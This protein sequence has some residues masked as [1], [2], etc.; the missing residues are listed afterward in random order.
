M[1]ATAINA[2]RRQQRKLCDNEETCEDHG[3]GG[4]EAKARPGSR[5]AL[6]VAR[7]IEV[8]F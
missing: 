3:N 1:E 7:E 8:Q 2:E 6:E 5:D 4:A